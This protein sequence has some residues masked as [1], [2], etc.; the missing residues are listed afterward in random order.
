MRVKWLLRR[1]LLSAGVLTMSI[2]VAGIAYSWSSARVAEPT[3]D[4]YVQKSTPVASRISGCVS[5]E[6]VED[7]QSAKAGQTLVFIDARNFRAAWDQARADDRAAQATVDDLP[8]IRLQIDEHMLDLVRAARDAGSIS[9]MDLLSIQGQLEHDRTIRPLAVSNGLVR[10][11]PVGDCPVFSAPPGDEHLISHDLVIRKVP[12]A[13]SPC[14]FLIEHA[15]RDAHPQHI[16]QVKN[17]RHGRNESPPR[18]LLM[19]IVDPS[20]Q[21]RR[22]HTFDVQVE[23]ETLTAACQ[24]ALQLQLWAWIDLL[25]RDIG[26]HVDEITRRRLRFEF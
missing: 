14:G 9:A 20:N 17:V 13:I 15:D 23:Y 3:G 25:M 10:R 6:K 4:A 18:A 5:A 12:I 24:H 2:T 8:V 1:Y 26:R 7:H 21:L 19:Q 16:A 11:R 22:R